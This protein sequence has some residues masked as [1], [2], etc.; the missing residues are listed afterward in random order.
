MTYAKQ[1]A[2]INKI[3][4]KVSAARPVDTQQAYA[5]YQSQLERLNLPEHEHER[6]CGEIA[7]RLGI[8]E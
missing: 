4:A 6:L 1:K 3:I 5:Y 8:A 2:E 7:K